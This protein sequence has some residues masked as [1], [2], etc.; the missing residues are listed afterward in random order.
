MLGDP[1]KLSAADFTQYRRFANWL[2]GMEARYSIMNFRQ[3]LP[4]FGEPME[5]GWDGF[6]RINTEDK[7]GGI[8]GVF[9]QGATEKQRM[10]T[11]DFLDAAVRYQVKTMDGKIIVTQTGKEL[12]EKG[13]EVTL[14]KLYDG[15][16]FEIGRL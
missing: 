5:G 2:Q 3:D 1:R 14:E 7:T 13:F 4:G 9:R 12:F 10:V 6:S 16:L 8:I 15:E 11:V